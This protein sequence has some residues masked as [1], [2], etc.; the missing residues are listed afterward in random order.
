MRLKLDIL[1]AAMWLFVLLLI[2]W[3]CSCGTKKAAVAVATT[4]DTT[5]ATVSDTSMVLLCGTD[6]TTQDD[7]LNACI[8]ENWVYDSVGN[9]ISKVSE[10]SVFSGRKMVGSRTVHKLKN[11][12]THL[13]I[14]EKKATA[15]AVPNATTREGVAQGKKHC[16]VVL[17]V[18]LLGLCLAAVYICRR[19]LLLHR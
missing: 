1:C 13:Q 10:I 15:V 9:V 16:P 7:T 18:A 8:T 3:L 6:T 19:A 5:T 2:A 11:N 4:T 17:T 14:N 12:V